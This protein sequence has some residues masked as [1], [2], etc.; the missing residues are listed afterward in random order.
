[1]YKAF[2]KLVGTDVDDLSKLVEATPSCLKVVAKDGTLL[3]MNPK[4]LSLIDAKDFNR[5]AGNDVYDLVCPEDR[6]RYM[7]FNEQVCAGESGTMIFDIIG[8]KGKRRTM[9]TFAGPYTLTTGEVAQIAITNDISERVQNEQ[10]ILEQEQALED[11]ARLSSLGEFAAN[12]AHEINNPLAII[13]GNA[14]LLEMEL[15]TL[16]P[17]KAGS[18]HQTLN[19]MISTI[20]RTSKIIT[21]LKNFSRTPDYGDL[22]WVR[23]VEVVNDTLSLCSQRFV[24]RGIQVH[25][26]IP[27]SVHVLCEP[28]GLNQIFMNLLN[29]S[30]D[31]I[32]GTQGAWIRVETQIVESKLQITVTDSG[33]GI[34]QNIQK[35]LLQPFFT[36]KEPGKGTGLGLSISASTLERMHGRLFYNAKHPNTQFVLEFTKHKNA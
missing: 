15:A 36:T 2:E 3:Q 19:T 11:A 10:A 28:V 1:M 17:A 9:E 13:Y 29:N 35:K 4:G 24:D 27:H 32:T 26:S 16:D 25:I 12:I 8:L 18:V 20:E 6:S 33:P 31:A 5:V 22:K 21:S 34:P 7:A 14:Q 30:S 23:A